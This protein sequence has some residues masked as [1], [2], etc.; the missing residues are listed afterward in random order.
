M[1]VVEHELFYTAIKLVEK[2]VAKDVVAP[3]IDEDTTTLVNMVVDPGMQVAA[4]ELQ[5]EYLPVAIVY[6]ANLVRWV[7]VEA[8]GLHSVLEGV[9][10]ADRCAC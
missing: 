9:I 3:S 1:A 7:V 5:V 4:E 6:L 8:Y 2:G 10:E